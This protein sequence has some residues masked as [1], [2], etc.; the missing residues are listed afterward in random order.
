M[1]LIKKKNDKLRFCIDLCKLNERT[2]K[3][4]HSIPRIHDSHNCPHEAVWFTFLDLKSGYLQ[5]EWNEAIKLSL[6]LWQGL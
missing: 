3:D 4:V 5:V 1:V 6:L 2:V